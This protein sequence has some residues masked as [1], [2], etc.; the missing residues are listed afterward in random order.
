MAA[1]HALKMGNKISQQSTLSMDS[2]QKYYLLTN[3]KVVPMKF[4]YLYDFGQI[5]D[6]FTKKLFLLAFS[7]KNGVKK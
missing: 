2:I 5:S 7:E 3:T 4:V 6:C 1:W